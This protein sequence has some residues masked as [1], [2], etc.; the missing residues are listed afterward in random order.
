MTPPDIVVAE[1]ADIPVVQ[2]L[3]HEIWLAHYPGI[4][5]VEQIDYMLAR[6]YATQALERYLEETGAGLALAKV[7]MRPVGFAA[8]Y[9]AAATT[10]LDRLY[11]LPAFQGRGIGRAMIEHIE[12]QARADGA[13]RLVLNVN[14]RNASTIALYRRCGFAVD[15]EVV[16]DIGEGFVMDDYVMG[17]P[18]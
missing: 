6:G 1:P 18:L 12:R 8:W 17:K 16:V 11:V 9:R 5:S 2:Q 7:A 14:K 3:A 4:I 15:E 13:T 10:K